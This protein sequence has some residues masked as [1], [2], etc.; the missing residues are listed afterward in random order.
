MAVEAQTN[1]TAEKPAGAAVGPAKPTT[2]K[3]VEAKPGKAKAA[4]A[5]EPR[6]AQK[7]TK[8]PKL[9]RKAYEKALQKLQVELCH[10]QEWV[11]AHGAR[12]IIV[13]EGRDTAGKSGLIRVIKERVSNRVFRVVALGSPTEER[14]QKLFMQRYI[15]Q[16]P[17]AGE[18]VIF[19]R[20]WYNR[21]GVERV[22]GFASEKEVEG[23]LGNVAKFERWVT[24]SGIILIKLWLEISMDEQDRR[25]NARLDDPLR[26]WKF[27]PMDLKSY[28]KWYEYSHARD[29]MFAASDHEAAPWY[30][31][32]SDH[33]KRARLNGIGHILSRVPYK[34]AKHD[35]PK[36]PKRSKKCKYNDALD[37]ENVHLVPAI[38]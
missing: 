4:K 3:K 7:L 36:L 5:K 17:V 35:R 21:A 30:V 31:L 22:L 33:K 14:R 25:L 12:V 11:K 32:P 13:L 1:G 37:F 18:V 20:S 29:E 24:A 9:G 15:E 6:P 26:Q 38:Y 23:F 16:F 10:L 2:S 28:A 27:S 34:V 8:R 19:D